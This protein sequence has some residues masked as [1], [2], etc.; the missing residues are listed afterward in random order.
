MYEIGHNG[1]IVLAPL[2]NLTSKIELP[3]LEESPQGQEIIT[4]IADVFVA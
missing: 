1:D 4:D 3:M 2:G